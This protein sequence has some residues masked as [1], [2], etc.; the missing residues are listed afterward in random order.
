MELTVYLAGEIHSGWREEIM[1]GVVAAGLPVEILAPVTDH[2]ASDDVGVEILGAEEKPF[3]K[4]HKGASINAIRT[5]TAIE[6]ADVVVARFG[7][8][9]RQWIAAFEA[10]QAVA[11]GCHLIVMHDES[12]THAL[13]EVDAAAMAVVETP[14]QVVEILRYVTLH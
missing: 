13:K 2:S 4:D 14:G 3:W 5:R 1:S 8:Q 10:G 9:Y 12:L 11:L 7:D 6:R